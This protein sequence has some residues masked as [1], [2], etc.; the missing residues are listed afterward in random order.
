MSKRLHGKQKQRISTE[1]YLKSIFLLKE[2]NKLDP[3]PIDIVNELMLSKGSVSE[4]LKK[5]DD[6]GFLKYESYG[7][8][9]L[10]KKGFEKAKNVIRKYMIVIEFLENVL[11][12]EKKKLHKEAC[13]LEHAFSDESVA[14]LNIVMKLL[15]KK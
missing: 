1:M 2:K 10:T 5:L 14:R 6:E 4:M 13:N 15:E 7:K 8:V 12:I 11:K 9:N 3:R